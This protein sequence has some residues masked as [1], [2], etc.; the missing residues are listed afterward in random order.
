MKT[1]AIVF[2]LIVS[3]GFAQTEES[4]F[5]N[6]FFGKYK[7][8]LKITTANGSQEIDMEFHLLPSDTLGKYHYTIIYKSDKINQERKYT[9]VEKDKAKGLYVVDENNGIL[10]NT[11]FA[12]NALYSIFEVQGGLLTTIEH[13][14][15]D[16]MDFE[17]MY[18]LKE[19]VEKSGDSGEEIPEVLSYP[20]SS[21][22]TARL[23]KQ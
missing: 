15:K 16:Y 19:K 23:Y 20:V 14:N 12:N 11:M 13:F 6:D 4:N 10:L 1:I 2:L 7:G 3:L 18:S 9:L 5:P 21:V 22:Q 8:K 17:I